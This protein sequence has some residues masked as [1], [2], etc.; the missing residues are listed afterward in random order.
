MDSARWQVVQ[1]LFHEA[2][3]KPR[4]LQKRHLLEACPDDPSLAAQVLA[5]LEED[6]LCASP[7]DGEMA[8]YVEPLLES[9][10]GSPGFPHKFGP[11]RILRIL[12]QGGM[13][14]VWLGQR[15]DL[16][17]LVAIKFLRD[18]WMSPARRIRFESEQRILAQLN[19]PSIA[20]IY[21][22]STLTD[23]TPW[24][25]M[26]Y[27][28]GV[29]LTEY[30]VQHQCS[31]TERLRLFRAVCDAVQYA[32]TR[33][34]VHRDLKPSNI[35]VKADG[36]VKLLDFGIAKQLD[37][38]EEPA[39]RTR[40]ELRLMT[41][42]YAAPEQLRGEP[43]GIFTDVYALGVIL[44]EI[45]TSQLP[46]DLTN[47]TPAQAERIIEGQQPRRPSLA[48][49]HSSAPSI[50]ISPASWA[51][52]DVLCLTAIQKDI[53]RRYGSAE[54]M[55][56][57]VDHFLRAEPLEARPDSRGYRLGKFARRNKKPL[58][59]AALVFTAIA[60]L[61]LFFTWRLTNARNAALGSEARTQRVQQFTLNL[62]DGGDALAGPAQNLRVVNLLD[63]G[64][65]QANNLNKDPALQAEL[66]QTLGNAYQKLGDLARADSLL[67]SALSV[68]RMHA[69]SNHAAI[70]S[71]LVALGILR[72]GQAKLKDGERL[73]R[74]GLEQAKL[75]SPADQAAVAKATYALGKV[76][77]ARGSYADAIPV[78]E[79]SVKLESASPS[80]TTELATSLHEL[81][82]THFYLGHYDVSD[83]L[84]RRAL[85]IHRQLFGDR[86]PSVADDL[87]DLATS[88]IQRGRY[89]EAE[90]LYREAL[91]IHRNWYGEEHPETASDL[92][93]LA[94]SLRFQNRLDEAEVL[95]K[96]ALRIQEHVYGPA[97][98]RVA[99]VLNE[100]GRVASSRQQLEEAEADYLRALGIYRAISGDHS[101]QAAVAMSNLA[102]VYLDR[103]D[104]V[105]AEDTVR[106]AIERFTRALPPNHLNMGIARIRLGQ[107]LV[108]QARYA[109][110]EQQVLAGYNILKSQTSPQVSWLVSAR[111]DLAVIYTALKQPAKAARY[112]QELT[113]GGAP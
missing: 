42:A 4:E 58:S 34:I 14:V 107:T 36:T 82:G 16:N 52:L 88:Q 2:A 12:G 94:Q 61:A 66:F 3:E 60:G 113:E 105:R 64:V 6:W 72:I 28:E 18:A 111:R 10:S 59:I 102:T 21:D 63:R 110:A 32:H 95:L 11:Y 38:F 69:A 24:F 112:K 73:I 106:D 86:H 77:E 103:K 91:E 78:L 68:R 51:D 33:L 50:P 90:K 55:V 15:E 98:P 71:S 80:A 108:C 30:C 99:L 101:Y 9:T 20:Q 39:E 45:L 40:T 26:E 76:L 93:T 92:L 8:T 62:F 25:V 47:R 65:Q 85:A 7:L 31:L 83:S 89:A 19:H 54:A 46:H 22:A 70:S 87:I 109:E 53:E 43:A 74:D 13:G 57:D 5:L 81:A 104:C 44:Y 97:H 41:P 27:V 48:A 29:S 79:Q 67:S 100:L 23:G 37:T 75:S 35:L 49:L 1:T 56:R 96:E 17:N 84:N